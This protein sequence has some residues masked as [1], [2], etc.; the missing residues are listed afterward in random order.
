MGPRD[1]YNELRVRYMIPEEMGYEDA[2]KILGIWQEIQYNMYRSYASVTISEDVD[3]NTVSEIEASTDLLG[4]NAVES[5]VRV[6]PKNL[7]LIHIFFFS[8][9]YIGAG[10]GER[11]YETHRIGVSLPPEAGISGSIGLSLYL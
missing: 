10:K 3:M 5:T 2:V 8:L 7:S 9:C 6:Y 1:A 11:S 4:V